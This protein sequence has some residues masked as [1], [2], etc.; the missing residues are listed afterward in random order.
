M[1][2]SGQSSLKDPSHH[3]AKSSDR[4]TLTST[5]H[6]VPCLLGIW[7]DLFSTILLSTL[8]EG[9]RRCG[10]PR[11]CW[12][13]NIKEWTSLP[14][15]EQ[16]TRASCRT[17]WNRTSA[18]SSLMSP[19]RLYKLRGWI[20]LN[21]FSSDTRYYPKVKSIICLFQ[22]QLYVSSRCPTTVP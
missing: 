6:S 21:W 1:I 11:K 18:E 3:Q 15:P 5:S 7:L 2:L 12:M 22:Q 8:I 4:R 9:G 10:R 16:L 20:E 14:K 19:R 13:D 17:D